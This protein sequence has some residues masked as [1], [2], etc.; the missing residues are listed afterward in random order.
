MSM[1]TKSGEVRKGSKGS[2]QQ[3]TDRIRR[4]A[5]ACF[6]QL[7]GRTLFSAGALQF[8]PIDAAVKGFTFDYRSGV[9]S[10]PDGKFLVGGYL[11]SGGNRD[12]AVARYSNV[13]GAPVLDTSF[14]G[15]D[16]VATVDLG[17]V[18]QGTAVALDPA[19]NVLVTGT[20]G[21]PLLGFPTGVDLKFGLARLT[22]TGVV[23]STFG[24]GDGHV[25]TTLGTDAIARA[26]VVQSDGSVVV[27]GYTAIGTSVSLD[28][29]LA[30]Y[31]STGTSV[32]TSTTDIGAV[33]SDQLTDLALEPDNQIVVVGTSNNQLVV[34]RYNADAATLDSSFDTDGKAFAAFGAGTVESSGV[35][36]QSDGRILAAGT[37]TNAGNEDF[38]IARFTSAGAA[39]ATFSGDGVL[40][41]DFDQD[42]RAGNIAL[43]TES[44]GQKIIASGTSGSGRIAVAR[45]DLSGNLDTTF[46]TDGKQITAVSGDAIDQATGLSV[47]TLVESGA[48]VS[49]I[50]VA[51]AE[52]VGATG[53][54]DPDR[55]RLAGYD[56][57]DL[58]T[59][60][61]PAVWV[62]D[63]WSITNDVGPAGLSAGDTVFSAEGAG[64]GDDITGV[65][66]VDAFNV[67]QNGVNGVQ[68]GGTVNVLAGSYTGSVTIPKALTLKSL[69]G[70]DETFVSSINEIE[71]YYMVLIKA[72]DVTVDGF[73][74]SHPNYA[75]TADASG[76]AAEYSSTPWTNLKILNNVIHD[77]GATNRPGASFG[78]FGINVGPTNGLEVGGNTVYNIGNADASSLAVGILTYGESAAV[79][80]QNVS[81]HDN[82]VH[83]IVHS[84]FGVG[85]NAGGNAQLISVTNNTV[86]NTPIG[87]R[88]SSSNVGSATVTGNTLGSG[89]T[90]TQLEL[91]DT[92]ASTVTGNTFT[93]TMPTDGKRIA[94]SAG[95][96]A[97]I[98]TLYDDNTFDTAVSVRDT[99][100]T[101]Q[102]ALWA[103]VQG[104]VNAAV[105]T[106]IVHAYEGVYTENGN[107]ISVAK[108]LTLEGDKVGVDARTRTATNESIVTSS[109]SAVVSGVKIDGFTFDNA[110]GVSGPA[111]YTSPSAS[112]YVVANNIIKDS[113]FGL[114]LH[115]EGT[116]QTTVEKNLFSNNNVGFGVA[117]AAGN[118][119]YSDQGLV[120]AF[121]QDNKITGH[122]NGSATL[123]GNSQS[124]LTIQR[125]EVL[126]DNGMTLVN[127]SSA[128]L[129]QNIFTNTDSAAI[130]ALGGVTNLNVT[131]NTISDGHWRDIMVA[132][133][134]NSVV[135]ISGN[136]IT[137]NAALFGAD[138]PS[139]EIDGAGGNI[140]LDNNSI[141]FSGTYA[142]GVTAAGGIR[143]TNSTGSTVTLSKN[144][145][146][147]GG[148]GNS[149]GITVENAASAPI[150]TVF[151]TDNTLTNFTSGGSVKNVTTLN[152][153]TDEPAASTRADTF[154][155]NGVE[156][157]HNANNHIA[158]QGVATLN[159]LTHGGVDTVSVLDSGSTILVINA[160][161][162][163]GTNTFNYETDAV[164]AEDDTVEIDT[165]AAPQIRKVGTSTE[166]VF[167]FTNFGTTDASQRNVRTHGGADRVLVTRISGSTAIDFT[168]DGGTGDDW[169][170]GGLGADKVIGAAGN[171]KIEGAN[172]NDDLDGG[173]D[174]DIIIGGNGND[175]LRAGTGNNQ[176]FG[177]AGNDTIFAVNTIRDIVDGGAGTDSAQ[178][179]AI[180]QRTSIEVLLP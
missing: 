141:T 171:D 51:G 29:A 130:N 93:G 2:L 30:K 69:H 178:L 155:V 16:G 134:G 124:N 22:S 90:Q 136:T 84:E 129:T 24:G 77:I 94:A 180:D 104:G 9:V 150:P 64:D 161:G 143:V 157:W 175:I 35:A 170:T 27:G 123:V 148:L 89:I 154:T 46:D 103:N 151:L 169:L 127:V 109:L 78:T 98:P 43:Q 179:D 26:V 125:N 41:T 38:A 118:A 28:F 108:T 92:F 44:G 131:S 152:Y 177:Q 132:G 62:N 59:A 147:G 15:G 11:E 145:L 162:G 48:V 101:Y 58:T 88:T 137:R 12:F 168:I 139:I 21:T 100:G 81:I 20:T 37:V 5:A 119:I 40:T 23:D 86:T 82:T 53:N 112:G 87:I 10:Q 138:R 25:E 32:T 50:V 36:L 13:G 42:D 6:E 122:Q 166:Q 45:Y 80:I 56:V 146:D 165:G 85:I 153:T 34:A 52:A 63:D 126:N 49:R 8:G 55:L 128:T 110:V 14:G 111:V 144:I 160:D 79:P 116:T 68:A 173:D 61:P 66:G 19:G 4:A 121:I 113:E 163:T 135:A 106:N 39:D 3:G 176:L 70:A 57:N 60:L 7:E 91:A 117:P 65:F 97:S 133:A 47:Q 74:I 96:A 142:S 1:Q 95:Y 158:H 105:A 172:G 174:N 73:D 120:K 167:N 99:S 115:S 164:T 140:T 83:D 71:D 76:V 156:M 114:Y 72:N 149:T 67:I 159:V 33:S 107:Q 54:P 75:E 31:N 18:D 17:G 102:P